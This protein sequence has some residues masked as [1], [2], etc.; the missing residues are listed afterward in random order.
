MGRGIGAKWT[1]AAL[2]SLIAPPYAAMETSIWDADYNRGRAALDAGDYNG[3]VSSLKKALEESRQFSPLDD[4]FVESAYTLAL[5]YYMQGQSAQAE[6]LYLESQ[7]SAEAMGAKG[8][9][10]I[11]YILQSLSEVRFDQN[12]LPESEA[13]L[14]RAVEVCK[15][16]HGATGPCT[17]SA[18]RHLGEVLSAQGS[19]AEAETV[20]QQL[21]E[22]ARNCPS[23]QPKFLAQVLD[24]LA[25]V[26]ITQDRFETAEPLLRESLALY[27]QNAITGPGMADTL[28]DLGQFYRLQHNRARAEP[29]LKKA[30]SIYEAAGDPHQAGALVELGLTAIQE[31]KFAIAKDYLSRSLGLYQKLVGPAH[32]LLA[33]V[34]AGLA[35]AFLGERQLKQ[36]REQI[37][38]ALKIERGTRGDRHCG[39]ARLLMI[40]G[41]IEEADHRKDDAQTYYTQALGIYRRNL[42]E[43]QPERSGAE[44]NYARFVRAVRK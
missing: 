21:A 9:P 26:Y 7:R 30:L 19:F 24:N 14:R 1:L 23:L 15:D 35:Q 10:L 4:R 39:Y 17:V 29:L 3:A 40:A 18:E 27:S 33:R 32:L 2:S 36:A 31:G 6:P 37:A 22:K 25:A 43:D 41:Q 28:V 13:L 5:T 38:E 16:T 42:A 34:K 8:R 12:R 11:G 20:L 44:Q